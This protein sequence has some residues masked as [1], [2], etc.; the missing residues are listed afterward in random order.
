MNLDRQKIVK[1]VHDN[2]IRPVCG[3]LLD[4]TVRIYDDKKALWDVYADIVENPIPF[5]MFL[6]KVIEIKKEISNPS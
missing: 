1:I 2:G 3:N 6:L 5:L 4:G